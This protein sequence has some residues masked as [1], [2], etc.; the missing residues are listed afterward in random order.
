MGT[1][2]ENPHVASNF[3]QVEKDL[4]GEDPVVRVHFKA[5][6][7]QEV[8]VLRHE[9]PAFLLEP[10]VQ[11]VLLDYFPHRIHVEERVPLELVLGNQVAHFHGDL[12]VVQVVE[13]CGGHW[14]MNL[15]H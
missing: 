12:A 4:L 15:V 2:L 14:V 9:L 11:A 7:R 6:A 5:P 1:V 8:H 10:F 3:V 13:L